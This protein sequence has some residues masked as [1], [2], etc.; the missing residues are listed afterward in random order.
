M[1]P[2]L[3]LLMTQGEAMLPM[4]SGVMDGPRKK[5]GEHSWI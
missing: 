1:G 2:F 5:K 4:S 3:P